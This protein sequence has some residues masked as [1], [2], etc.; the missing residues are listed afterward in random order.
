MSKNLIVYFSHRKQN[1][2]AGRI[3]ELEVGNTEVIAKKLQKLLDADVFKIKPL[4]DYPFDY[5]EC[6]E[7]AKKELSHQSRPK[8]LNMISHIQD[9]Q[10]IYL[11]YP[12]WWGTMPMCVWTFLESYDLSEKSIYPFCTHE[13]SGMGNSV[14]DLQKLCP[15]ISIHKGLAIYGSQ[16]LQSDEIIEQWL[17]EEL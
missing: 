1:Y 10:K 16:V 3:Q 17:N 4:H 6:T 12:N 15:K 13:G 2:V 8:I 11:G 14:A 7:I 5:H 9:Y